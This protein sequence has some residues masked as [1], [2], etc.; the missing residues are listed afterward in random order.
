[1]STMSMM[2]LETALTEWLAEYYRR[3]SRFGL[4][5]DFRG[6]AATERRKLPCCVITAETEVLE[7]PSISKLALELALMVQLDDTRPRRASRAAREIDAHLC[8][9]VQEAARHFRQ[10]GEFAILKARTVS[11]RSEIEGERGRVWAAALEVWV[12]PV[13]QVRVVTPP[14]EHE[15]PDGYELVTNEW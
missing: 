9:A 5:I 15:C 2:S 13:N 11:P 8:G 10:V 6:Q 3:V 12:G 1:M 7:H 14:E 4:V